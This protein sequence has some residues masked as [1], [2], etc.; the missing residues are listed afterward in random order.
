MIDEMDEG[1]FIMKISEKEVELREL[2]IIST[3]LKDNSLVKCQYYH[4]DYPEESRCVKD[5]SIGYCTK[6]K[7][8]EWLK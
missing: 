1:I 5:S 2:E 6:C 3:D 4:S 7:F 8:K